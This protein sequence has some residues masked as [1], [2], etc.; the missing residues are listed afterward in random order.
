MAV[1]L[2]LFDLDDTLLRTAD[3]E[4]GFRG[5]QYAGRQAQDYVDRLRAAYN[6]RENRI[7]YPRRFLN[8]LR[9]R[10][11]DVQLGVFTKAPKHYAQTL[12]S[13]AYPG[14]EWDVLVAYEDVRYTKPNGEGIL[15]AMD[16]AGVDDPWAVWMVG[17]TKGDIQA[18]YDAGCWAVLDRA[19]WPNSRRREDWW[20]LERMPDAS[21]AQ[22]SELLPVLDAPQ[23][24][25][26]IAERLQVS[27]CAAIAHPAAR[28]EKWNAFDLDGR[29][30][31]IH[32][33]GR[34]FSREAQRRVNWHQ[35]THDIH[36]M[37]DLLVVPDYWIAAIRA[38]LKRLVGQHPGLAFG[39]SL[40]VTVIP[41]KPTRIRR[42][43]A[44]L[45]QLAESH[46]AGAIA[47]IARI[48][49]VPDLLRYREGVQSQHGGDG[50]NKQQRMENVRDHLEVV[51]GAGYRGV[52][53]VV[54][55]DV[56]TTGASLVYANKYLTEAGASAVTCLSLTK[57]INTQ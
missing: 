35:V 22:P 32:Y 39:G 57:A 37:K 56:A 3:L 13:I 44:M 45:E 26:P 40:V 14:F 48:S 50:L 5:T 9:E 11:P 6:T 52:H 23:D 17:D 16:E 12:L 51:D 30:Y 7:V 34:H 43:E 1:E 31:P 29:V 2:L 27:D 10:Y 33:L 46:R 20:A 24:Y 47:G 49:F 53:V 4:Q 54:I 55:D 41:A 19:T 25:L 28:F 38:F 8:S 15:L 18:A 36:A 21:I 42:L